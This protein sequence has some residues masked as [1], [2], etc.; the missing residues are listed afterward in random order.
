MKRRCLLTSVLPLFAVICSAPAYG[1]AGDLPPK[2]GG[3]G[4][5]Q[6]TAKAPSDFS[7]EPLVFEYLRTVMRYENDGTGTRET[8]AKIHV[9]S[10]AGL[11]KAG[12]LIFDYN[13]SNETV[14]IRSVLVRKPDGSVVTAGADAVQDLS[15][16]VA[17][18]APMYTDA[19]QKHV[20]VPSL[21]VG[22][23]V[24]YDV[25]TS[26]KPLLPG[27]FWNTWML[28]EAAIC[29]DEQIELNVPRE[30]PLKMK[31]P[32]GVEATSRDDGERRIY[33]WKTSNL[34]VANPFEKLKDRKF[35]VKRLLEGMQPAP[36][37]NV[38]FSTFQS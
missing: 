25:V 27:Q 28:E 26:S 7:Q 1:Q 2:T 3:N 18:E 33:L 29:L 35:D 21:S 12:Q 14:E 36:A 6:E 5:L 30:R 17:R 13:A 34:K 32:A 31:G 24:E 11:T 23:T 37:R 22:D 10:S 19:R 8:V 15:A 38:E 9:Q 20:T 4:T 16:P